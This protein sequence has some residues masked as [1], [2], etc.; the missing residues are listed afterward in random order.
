MVESNISNQWV[1]VGYNFKTEEGGLPLSIGLG[2]LEN[3]FDYGKFVVTGSDR[4]EPIGEYNPYEQFKSIS[5]GASYDYYLLFNLGFSIKMYKSKLGK[6]FVDNRIEESIATGTAF[7]LGLM[8]TTP[9]TKLVFN[10]YKINLNTNSSLKPNFDF[11]LG[12]SLSNLGKEVIYSD[13]AQA[14][15]LPRMARLGYSFNFSLEFSNTKVEKFSFIDYSFTAESDDFLINRNT[16]GKYE[17]QN[18][19]GGIK[20]VKHL[21]ELKGDDYVI[22]HKGHILRLFETLTLVSGR[23]NG[24]GYDHRKTSGIGVSSEGLFKLLNSA[25]DVPGLNYFTKHFVCEYYETIIFKESILE[26]RMNG[27]VLSYKG[28]FF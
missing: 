4:P 15:P 25:F 21:I 13:P 23:F 11:T 14:D 3:K 28:F 7:D 9:I 2:Y 1:S 24:R 5:I 27:I 20:P 16:T 17:Y 22:V 8:V 18:P 26:T 12:Y 10:D 19:F 6:Y